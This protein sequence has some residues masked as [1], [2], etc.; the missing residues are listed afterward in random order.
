[1]KLFELEDLRADF[2][3]KGFQKQRTKRA[4]PILKT[5][6]ELLTKYTVETPPTLAFG[7]AIAYTLDNWKQ[8]KL[9]LEDPLLTPSNN[10]AENTI[11]P[12]VIGRKN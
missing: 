6:F 8:L 4:A 3:M 2:S 12:F 1:M 10:I 9:Y 5:I 7:K 11:R